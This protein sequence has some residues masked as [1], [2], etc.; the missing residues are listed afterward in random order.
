MADDPYP[1]TKVFPKVAGVTGV[2]NVGPEVE[3][4]L[5]P[6]V[7]GYMLNADAAIAAAAENVE[8]MAGDIPQNMWTLAAITVT[9]AG[10]AADAT[11]GTV[12]VGGGPAAAD[13]TITVTAAVDAGED[14]VLTYGVTKDDNALAVASGVQGA[15]DA[16]AALTATVNGTVVTVSPTSGTNLVKLTATIA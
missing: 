3:V 13:G 10:A 11:E 14:I 12:T 9:A 15:V 1:F 16:D 7:P 8:I 5:T 4:T 2:S 6:G